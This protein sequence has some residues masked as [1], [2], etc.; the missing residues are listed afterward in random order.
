LITF[1]HLSDIHVPDQ[2]GDVWGG[3]DICRKLDTLIALAEQLDFNPAFTVITGDIFHTGT[4]CSYHLAKRYIAK[5]QNLGRPIIPLMGTWTTEPT[6]VTSC[7][8][9]PHHRMTL[10]ATT[11][12][13]SR[14][15]T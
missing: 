11:A 12:I 2:Q 9:N 4:E 1:F 3:V 6:S 13:Q 10:P 14:D 8:R 15:S 7:W 5:I